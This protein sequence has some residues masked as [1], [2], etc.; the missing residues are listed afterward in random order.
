MWGSLYNGQKKW[1]SSR[2][3]VE[4]K[5]NKDPRKWYIRL[6]KCCCLMKE[7]RMASEVYLFNSAVN[8]GH[9]LMREKGTI[10]V[11]RLFVIVNQPIFIPLVTTKTILLY[12]FPQTCKN[13]ATSHRTGPVAP[14]TA[15]FVEH[16]HQPSQH[17]A[18]PLMTS[19]LRDLT[20]PGQFVCQ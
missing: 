3:P 11:N 5:S 8:F 16:Q 9:L 10:S 4:L 6:G 20:W 12:V 17:N 13:A 1:N 19:Y 7:D 14:A 18:V 2:E 15:T